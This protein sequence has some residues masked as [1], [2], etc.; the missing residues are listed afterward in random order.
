RFLVS[1]PV[2]RGSRPARPRHRTRASE[3]DI[4]ACA[5]SGCWQEGPDHLHIQS[6]VAGPLYPPWPVSTVSNLLLQRVTRR[7]GGTFGNQA[8]ELCSAHGCGAASAPSCLD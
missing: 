3:A 2:V 8:T 7:L 5:E 6:G 4:G 1:R